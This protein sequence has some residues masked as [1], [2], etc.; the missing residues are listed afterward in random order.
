MESLFDYEFVI[1]VWHKITLG[2]LTSI[3]FDN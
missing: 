1:I 3:E 2:P